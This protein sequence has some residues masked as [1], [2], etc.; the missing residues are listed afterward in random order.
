MGAAHGIVDSFFSLDC[1]TMPEVHIFDFDGVLFYSPAPT[2]SAVASLTCPAAAPPCKSTV[3]SHAEGVAAPIEATTTASPEKLLEA[4]ANKLY[5]TLLNPVDSGGY[6]WFQSLLTMTPPC[7]PEKPDP[8]VWFVTP[9]ITHMRALVARRNT[10]LRTPQTSPPPED[11]PLLYVLTGRDVKY[12][13]R[14]WTLLQQVGLDNQVEDVILKPHEMAGTVTYKLNN[15]FRIIQNH[16][17]SRVYYYE[18]RVEQGGR[19]LEGIRVLEEVLFFQTHGGGSGATTDRVGVVT[20]DVKQHKSGSTENAPAQGSALHT[21]QPEV[22]FQFST[23]TT[24]NQGRSAAEYDPRHACVV[25]ALRDSP[26]ALLREACYPLDR[27]ATF[28]QD[29]SAIAGESAQRAAAH[30]ER[31]AQRWVEGTIDF[32][33]ARNKRGRGRGGGGGRGGS[34]GRGAEPP[35]MKAAAA[36]FDTRALHDAIQFKVAPPFTFIMVLVPP[37]VCDRSNYM[38]NAD[39]F[40]ALVEGLKVEREKRIK[41]QGAATAVA[42]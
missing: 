31:R 42:A 38:L 23:N 36:E 19:L 39:Q 5:G 27:V 15:L 2:R 20:F 33:N 4:E 13:D 1:V 40:S 17:P 18:D 7:V 8:E 32:W 11:M 30:A 26:Y 16:R 29:E 14:I 3:E 10:L 21:P 12:Y 34:G 28:Y 22:F 6:G 41:E 9:I 25:K 24:N 37:A 35:S